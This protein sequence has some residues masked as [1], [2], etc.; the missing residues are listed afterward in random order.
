MF[1]R[2]PWSRLLSAYLNKF[3]QEASNTT[4]RV[5]YTPRP[6]Q[7]RS[8]SGA[9]HIPQLKRRKQKRAHAMLEANRPLLTPHT[10]TPPHH[11]PT[12]PLHHAPYS[13]HHITPLHTTTPH[14]M[15]SRNTPHTKSWYITHKCH[16]PRT[17]PRVTHHIPHL[18]A[19]HTSNIS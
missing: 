5:P 11:H 14:Q 3:V 15:T 10:T 1:V 8:T 7:A 18:K 2:D 12:T 4:H 16:A 6:K 9:A 17:T 13:K 19:H